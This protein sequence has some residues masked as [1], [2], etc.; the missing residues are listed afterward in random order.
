MKKTERLG[1][2]LPPI[3]SAGLAG[4]RLVGSASSLAVHDAQSEMLLE[5]VEVAIT[6]Q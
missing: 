1:R 5:R 3:G 4:V 2:S 6:V